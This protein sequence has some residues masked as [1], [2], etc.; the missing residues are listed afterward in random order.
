MISVGIVGA[1]GYTGEELAKI[2]LK[3]PKVKIQSLTS[4][5][6]EGK[7]INDTFKI[8]IPGVFKAPTLENLST[9]DVVFFATPNG[10][11][12]KMAEDLINNNIKVIDISAD[13]RLS[14]SND[15]ENWYNQE[16]H[17]PHLL[18]ESVYG[19]A[20]IPGQ[21]ELIKNAKIVANPGCYPTSALLG[22]LPIYK[23]LPEQHIIID[24]K[25]RISG[26]GGGI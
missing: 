4:R 13:F 12:M 9:C 3:H 1:S 24:A 7:N 10:V 20:E 11:A 16:H 18:A 2:L 15:Y 6:H 8:D 23:T 17:A 21:K 22:L 5:S 19:L 14:N 25:S 26:A